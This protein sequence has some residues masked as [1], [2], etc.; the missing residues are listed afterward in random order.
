ML[1][2]TYWLD[3]MFKLLYGIA[4]DMPN[5]LSEIDKTNFIVFYESIGNVLNNRFKQLYLD[6]TKNY[7]INNILLDKHEL[8]RWINNLEIKL[9]NNSDP[10]LLTNRLLELE[11]NLIN[12]PDY[13]IVKV[14]TPPQSKNVSKKIHHNISRDRM[15]ISR[16]IKHK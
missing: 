10:L 9:T 13:S 12:K 2:D 6:Y 11:K 4:Y 14:D 15:S 3:S 8:L 5:E 7:S 16:T 1:N